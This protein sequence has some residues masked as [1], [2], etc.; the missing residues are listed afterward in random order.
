MTWDIIQGN[1][2]HLI[3]QAKFRW[4]MLSGTELRSVAGDR[5]DLS[6]RIQERYGVSPEEAHAQVQGWED[7]AHSSWLY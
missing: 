1:W 5:E 6:A 4:D 3:G 2:P 7:S